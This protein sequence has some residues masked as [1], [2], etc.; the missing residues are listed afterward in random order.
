MLGDPSGKDRTRPQLTRDA[1]MTNARTYLDQATKVL[2]SDRLEVLNNAEWFLKFGF[3]DLIRLCSRVTVARMLE[4]DLFARRLEIG[5][6]IGIH[7][8]IYPLLQGWDSVQIRCDVELGGQDQIFNLLMGRDFQEQEGQPP[9]V[10]ITTPLLLGLDGVKK[11][12]KSEG[13]YIGV[14]FPPDDVYGKIMSIP[15]ELI[16]TYFTLLT[17]LEEETVK[18]TLA[19]HPR[20]AKALLART[21]T[22]DLHGE[23]QTLKAEEHFVRVFRERE[24]PEEIKEVSVEMQGSATIRILELAVK[25]GLAQSNGEARRLILGRGLRLNGRVVTDPELK[26]SLDESVL[27]QA[28][29]RRFV[30]ARRKV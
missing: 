7:E 14:H 10:C 15:D 12:S 26:V 24:L 23:E 20:D 27:L 18:T 4:R 11:M 16:E 30:R 21:I 2:R 25:T 3:G 22:R 1:V 9:Q 8:F 29:K 28:G 6:P 17:S 5:A 13:N 19:G